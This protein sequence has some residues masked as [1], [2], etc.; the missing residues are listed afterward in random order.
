[1]N[2]LFTAVFIASAALL[3]IFAP[4]KFLPTLLDGA[5]HSAVT[6]LTLFGVYAVWMGLAAVAEN[7]GITDKLAKRMVPLCRR[8]LNSKDDKAC[9]SAAMNVT[10]GLLGAGAATHFAIDAMKRFEREKN[11]RAIRI[12]FVINCAGFQ[13]MPSSA[14]ALRAAAGS[15]A[16][17]DIYLPTLICC[18]V[19]L[20]I[21]LALIFIC[22]KVH[23]WR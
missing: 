7:A 12:L 17:A 5:H 8:A 16:A 18:C 9:V 1:M 13:L 23:L 4:E 20:T 15:A 21:S 11:D 19:T 2:V 22:Q 6:A 14:V 3:A 10:C